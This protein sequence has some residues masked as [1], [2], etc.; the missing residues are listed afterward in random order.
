M[1]QTLDN[2]SLGFQGDYP[3]ASD[4]RVASGGAGEHDDL[5]LPTR[6]RDGGTHALKALRITPA[7]SIADHD[8]HT[9]IFR[10]DE[11]GTG[12]P[13]EYAELLSRPS[14]ELFEFERCA[15]QRTT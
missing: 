15:M 8:G 13:A 5:A 1:G 2:P 10:A 4:V 3:C 6:G 11:G 7:E 14:A 9:A 12:E